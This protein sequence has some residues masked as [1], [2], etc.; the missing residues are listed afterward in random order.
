MASLIGD[1]LP[2]VLSFAPSCRIWPK[3]AWRKTSGADLC[4]ECLCLW[5]WRAKIQAIKADWISLCNSHNAKAMKVIYI[6]ESD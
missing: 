4:S 6:T 1:A 3:H 2:C 5:T